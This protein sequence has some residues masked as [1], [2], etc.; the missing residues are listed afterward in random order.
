MEGDP[1]QLTCVTESNPPAQTVWRKHL[2]DG[3]TQHLIENN[4]LFIPQVH[5]TDSGRYI[6][7]VN[8]LVTN[9]TEKAAVDIVIQGTSLLEFSLPYS[10]PNQQ[11]PLGWRMLK[12]KIRKLR[13]SL[14]NVFRISFSELAVLVISSKCRSNLRVKVLR[15][16]LLLLLF[17]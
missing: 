14:C 6:C 3:S 11:L 15:T 8:N 17:Q 9:K 5:F 12:V 10:V 2:A 16:L 7:E 13:G 1:L 4:T